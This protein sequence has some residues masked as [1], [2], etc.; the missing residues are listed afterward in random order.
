M[1]NQSTNKQNNGANMK[2]SNKLTT[3]QKEQINKAYLIGLTVAYRMETGELKEWQKA[4]SQDSVL[5]DLISELKDQPFGFSSTVIT[6]YEKG[7]FQ[8]FKCQL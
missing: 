2:K 7:K 3:A 5:R 8:S 4:H 1:Y 6:A